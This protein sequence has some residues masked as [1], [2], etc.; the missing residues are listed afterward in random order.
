MHPHRIDVLDRADD[1]G[2]VRLVAD[3]LHLEF[4]PAEERLVDQDLADGRGFEPAPA[5]CLVI[6]A[7]IGDA[8]AG[9]AQGEGRP[10]DRRQADLCQ[11]IHGGPDAC[12]DVVLAVRPLRR[13]DDGGA[14][15]LQPDPLHRLAEQLAVLGHF[16]GG[17][18][19][20]DQ[21]D[22]ELL[23]DAHVG[24]RHGGV[25][26][27]LP[28]HRR[29]QRVGAFL[30]D[31]PGHHFRRD[32]LDVGCVRHLRI[33]HD[34]GGVR[35]DQD[36]PVALFLQRLAG[37]SA[38]IV[39]LASLADDDGPRADDH[40]RGDVGAF[41]HKLFP[42]RISGAWAERERRTRERVIA[43]LR[44]RARKGSRAPDYTGG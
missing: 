19:G 41:R 11:R 21:L 3:H 27:G 2:V 32:R 35:V 7:V 26:P 17:A 43:I 1:D 34:G 12:A 18:V 42:G 44:A 15:V 40:D 22:P 38:G 28:A 8:A 13:A 23:Q 29:Q 33:G 10:D 9:A 31:D 6:L 37:L 16:D 14:R 4:L 5:D 30:L 39:E 36:D 25:E 24:Q 20:A